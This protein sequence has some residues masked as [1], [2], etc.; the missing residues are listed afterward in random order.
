MA[1]SR[2]NAGKLLVVGVLVLLGTSVS[3]PTLVA[4]DS[5]K[6]G[7]NYSNKTV[8][9]D[10]SHDVTH[11]VV[12]DYN[13]SSGTSYHYVQQ[14][15]QHSSTHE[16]TQTVSPQEPKTTQVDDKQKA[17]CPPEKPVEKPCP[18][19]VEHKPCPTPVEH[20]KPCPT[21]VVEKHPCPKPEEQKQ[22]C[23]THNEHKNC[24]PKHETHQP[25]P[26]PPVTPTEGGKGGGPLPT[27]PVVLSAAVVAPAPQTLSDTGTDT[28]VTSILAS[29]FIAAAAFVATRRTRVSE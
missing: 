18:K 25:C 27:T 17:P 14:D 5:V 13:K 9:H 23:P 28:V 3:K 16:V 21:P 22:P 26:K 6:S 2:V 4:A 12:N 7:S 15:V 11:T 8:E 29:V 24:P 1:I 10:V 19:P 20:K